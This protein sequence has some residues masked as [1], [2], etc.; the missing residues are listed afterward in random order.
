MCLPVIPSEAKSLGG[1]S[2]SAR[3][4]IPAP[5]RHAPETGPRRPARPPA[6]SRTAA[7]VALSAAKGL[8]GG[9]LARAP[10]NQV[11]RC[12]QDDSRRRRASVPSPRA[13]ATS[14]RRHAPA[15][16]SCLVVPSAAR[17]LSGGPPATSQRPEPLTPTSL[18]QH[19]IQGQLA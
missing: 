4:S 12:A 9:T 15:A 3:W 18:D 19:E 11:L 2:T 8:G 6:R 16:T 10:P 13:V 17:D 5:S 1:E 7:L 14:L